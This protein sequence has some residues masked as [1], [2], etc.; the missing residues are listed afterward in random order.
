MGL[1][2][3]GRSL[4]RNLV[5]RT[6]VE[7]DLDEEVR[8]YVDLRIEEKRRAGLADR[9]ARRQTLIE[10]GGVEQ[11]K[12]RVRDVRV[13][14][15][16]EQV[17]QDV[18]YAVRMLHKH[19][20]F[21]LVALTTLALGVGATTAVFSVVDTVVFRPFPYQAP[22]RV[23]KICGTGPRD[24][25]CDDDFSVT[26]LEAIRGQTTAFEQVAADDGK[27]ASVSHS[28]GTRESIGIGLVSTNWLSTLGV[29]PLI[30]RDFAADEAQP[31]RDGILILTYDYWRRRFNGDRQV[32]GKTLTLDGAVH[33]IIGVL[34]PNVVRTYADVLVPLVTVGYSDPSLDLFGRLTPGVTSAQAGSELELI[35][36]QL[37]RQYPKTNE[38]RRLGV[39]RL[40]KYY[41]S[42][43]PK[44]R[45]GLVL[46]LGA[47][48]LVLLIACANVANLLLARAGARRR[49]SFLR[50]ALGASR[51]RL[52]R[53]LLLETVLLFTVGGLLGVLVARLS[54][55]SLTALAISGGYMPE[56][57]TADVDLRALGAALLISLVTG[58]LFGLVPALH[59]STVDLSG[60]LRGSAHGVSGGGHQGRARRALIVSE[61]ALSLLLLAGF[62]LLV[63]SFELLYV[64][65]GGFNP[66][67]VLET[68]SDGGRSFPQ[69]MT[70]WSAV[71]ERT[72]A[73]PGVASA[74]LTSRPPVH[75][76]RRKR[77][78]VAG[79]TATPDDAP[80]A[81]DIL[82]SADYFETL[83]I[84]LLSGRAFTASDNQS[85]R[86]VVIISQSVAHRYFGEQDP[87]GQRLRLL[88]EAPMTCCSA[89]APVE[90]VWREIVGVA[91]DVRQANLDDAP[92]LSI[93][94]H[95]TQIVE[96]DMYLLVRASSP[97][98]A[99]RIG[100]SLRGQVMALD[101]TRDWAD[102]RAMWQVISESDSIRLRRFVLI[103]LGSFA[104]LA[105]TLS[106][107]GLYGIAAGAVVERTKEIGVR[108]ALGATRSVVFRDLLREMM[109][110][111]AGGIVVG[112][113]G[114]LVLTRLI[115]S[116]LFGIHA[117]DPPT[118]VGV[119][120]LLGAVVL[121]ATYIP[122]RRAMRIDPIVAL[123]HE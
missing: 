46:M 76:A 45:Q 33:T 56:R 60:G 94:R 7:Q 83:R 6:R 41:G 21:T 106:A 120:L 101:P 112:S 61:L 63:R 30:G 4:W 5:H 67:N 121:V 98:A 44:A 31:G 77:F 16:V 90:G 87:I 58:V 69:A 82:V 15:L 70:F 51:A 25:A 11:V 55:N 118:Y 40:G 115:R 10:L 3:R 65:A 17:R 117:T 73:L 102:V 95:Y 49:E 100:A 93:Y 71:L 122:A 19:A 12:E 20:A 74:A 53:Q 99:M 107:V 59:T 110:L 9:D 105:L 103:L 92:A 34:P 96:H 28:D 81:G 36:R 72:H 85:S 79:S 109:M 78:I 48:G 26:E 2:P 91:G 114:A 54:L 1:I 50:T 22:D 80:E 29:R 89:P 64:A 35:G 37:Q 116:M 13:G 86:P 97:A 24:P 119:A 14:A 75:R 104:C 123:R 23:F 113:A 43:Q 88:D 52:V 111:A 62:G 42:V 27:T 32:V 38:G 39:E 68:S 8:S 108:I 57:L 66:E 18:S 84:P 47:V